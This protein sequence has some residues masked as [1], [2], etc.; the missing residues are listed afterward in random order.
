MNNKVLLCILDGIGLSNDHDDNAYYLANT[1]TLDMFNKQYSHTTLTCSGL[2]VGLP[3]GQMGNSEVGHLNIGAGRVVYQSLTLINKAIK[4]DT[5]KDVI[6][7]NKTID[8]VI[9]N[10]SN[11]HI[12]GLLSDGGVHS[13]IEHIKAL[14]DLAKYRGLKT[15][16]VH[17]FM[18]G[19]DTLSDSGIS[20]MTELLDYMNK[21]N[22]GQV[23]SISGRYY[24]M[25]RDKRFERNKLAYDAMVLQ[26]SPTFTNPI[27]YLKQSYDK[28]EYDEFVLPA[29]NKEVEGNIKDNDGVIF[30]NFRPDRA[31]QISSILT[32]SNYE[33]VF[34]KQPKNL[35]FVCMMKYDN[36]VLGDIAFSQVDLKNTLGLYLESQ[37]IKQLRIA[38]TEKYAHVTFFFDGQVKY[39]GVNNPEL[40][41]CD[42]ILVNSPKVATYDLQPEMSAFEVKDKLIEQ[43]ENNDHQVMILNFANGDMVG[44]TGNIK[45]AI[46]AVETVDT[47]LNEIYEACELHGITMLIT[48]D[49]GNCEDMIDESGNMLTAHTTNKVPLII[50]SNKHELVEGSLCD[51]APT[52]LDLINLKQPE[53]MTGKSLI[54]K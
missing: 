48:A 3:E 29:F 45:A 39:D 14:L 52:I 49:H 37:N 27:D 38:E 36:S 40:K 9:E 21:I 13:H 19:R 11:L 35:S 43:I 46:K 2:E 47:C 10:N 50:T 8:H 54:K 24:A 33:E 53:E 26:T 4:D 16:Y 44:H 34:E 51:I 20:F 7:F 31:I 5:F 41:G 32:N 25:D 18:D 6:A 28:E 17:A 42:R 22:F 1:P 30:A 12:M 23:A 15:A